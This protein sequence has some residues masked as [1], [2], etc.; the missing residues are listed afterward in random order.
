L[1]FLLFAILSVVLFW[2]PLRQW[3]TLSVR[4]YRYSH[5]I[6]LPITSGLLVYLEK[7]RIFAETRKRGLGKGAILVLAATGVYLT[8]WKYSGSLS[9]TDRIS[10]MVLAM[11]LVWMAGFIVC[12]GTRAFRCAAFPVLLLLLMVPVPSFLLVRIVSAL[13]HGSAV[14]LDWIFAL[15]RVPVYRSGLTFSLPG[16]S[17]EIAKECS[18][19]RSSMALLLTALLASHLFLRSHWKKAFLIGFIVPLV[20]IKNALRIATISL[21]SV[22]VNRNFLTGDLHRYGGIPFSIVSVSMLIP[23]LWGLQKSENKFVG[24]S[25]PSRAALPEPKAKP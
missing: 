8:G 17:I 18:G 7:G 3:A 10:L 21:L 19:I 22:Y 23:V 1:F 12:Y 4:D 14:T 2:T 6:L 11:V 15:V 13:Q 20:V 5:L 16:F 9:F 24:E 25:P